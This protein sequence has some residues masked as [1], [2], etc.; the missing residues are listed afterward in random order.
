MK[1]VAYSIALR[2]ALTEELNRDP[3]VFLLGEDIADFGGCFGVTRGMLKKYGPERIR[4]TPISENS[5]VGVGLGAALMGMRPVVEIMF[6]DFITLAMDQIVNHAAKFHYMYGGQVKVPMVIRTPAGGGR[7]YGATHSQ[8]LDSWLLSVP[9]IKVVAPA[10]PNDAKG[11]LK[12][13]IRDDNPVIMIE[14]K[15]LYSHI[16]EVE[17]GEVLVPIGK[18]RVVR[19]GE[20]VTVVSYSRM[21]HEALKAAD[22][23]AEQGVSV[24]VVDLRSLYPLDMDT[25]LQSVRKTRRVMVVEEGVKRW[26]V[27]AEIACRITEQCFDDLLAPVARIGAPDVPIPCAFDLEARVLP[28]AGRIEGGV[29]KM[30]PERRKVVGVPRLL[31]TNESVEIA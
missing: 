28:N 30:L 16:D 7:G 27:G 15:V 5:F 24:E 17:E 8:T 3:S 1:R 22:A 29:L 26:G 13:A 18:A 11:L 9:G 23:L 12:T 4:N 2:D 14:S 19:D 25:V 20:D 31:D 6:M 10:F 21:L